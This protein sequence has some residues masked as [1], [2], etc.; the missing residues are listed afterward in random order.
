MDE[1]HDKICAHID[2]MKVKRIPRNAKAKNA[3]TLQKRVESD[4]KVQGEL[5]A[6]NMKDLEKVVVKMSGKAN[7]QGHLFQGIHK[8]EIADALKKETRVNIDPEMIDLEHPI[9]SVGDH[10]IVVQAGESK[11]TFKLEIT[12]EVGR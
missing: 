12:G 4:R 2:R 10:E 8:D 11:A 9:K 3:E 6:K 5:L 1:L 7:E